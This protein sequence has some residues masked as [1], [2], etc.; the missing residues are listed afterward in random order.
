MTHPG[1][2][3]ELAKGG[4]SWARLTHAEAVAA[5]VA[6]THIE[7]DQ[8]WPPLDVAGSAH[9]AQVVSAYRVSQGCSPVTQYEELF[10]P[11]VFKARDIIP[12]GFGSPEPHDD[13]K[14][15]LIPQGRSWAARDQ[16]DGYVGALGE[17]IAWGTRYQTP[18]D[19]DIGPETPEGA[20]AQWIGGGPGEGHYEILHIPDYNVCGYAMAVNP[21][22]AL[23]VAIHVCVFGIATVTPPPDPGPAPRQLVIGERWTDANGVIAEITALPPNHRVTWGPIGKKGQL[24]KARH[25]VAE[26]AFR[27][28]FH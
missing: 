20:L 21:D 9:G 25:T 18:P 27:G 28:R 8:S 24:G 13:P 12:Y 1:I 3:A 22:P 16:D 14:Q 6:P 17:I 11:A 2:L 26:T 5:L 4:T 23:P 15:P 10:L 7:P 19:R